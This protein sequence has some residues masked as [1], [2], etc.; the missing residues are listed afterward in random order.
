MGKII[1]IAIG[2][3]LVGSAVLLFSKVKSLTD[4]MKNLIISVGFNGNIKNIKVTITTVTLPL[5]IDFANRSD[6]S[7]TLGLNAMDLIYKN[8]V[9][10]QNSPSATEAVIKPFTTVS[11]PVTVNLSVL[12]LIAVGGD[13]VRNAITNFSSGKIT[14]DKVIS[15]LQSIINNISLYLNVVI[16]RSINYGT[17]VKIGESAALSGFDGLGRP[18]SKK[19]KLKKRMKAVKTV[20]HTAVSMLTPEQKKQKKIMYFDQC[21]TAASCKSRYR[22]LAK[23]LHPDKEGGSETAFQKMQEEYEAK[24]RELQTRAPLNSQEAAELAKAILEI[25]RITKPQYYE[26]IRTVTTVPSVNMLAT[27]FGSLFPEKK[28]TLNGILSILK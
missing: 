19:F 9:I 1:K 14:F 15:E 23:E 3:A 17:T 16:N 6:T 22:E 13:I 24:L 25:L 8:K 7:I 26:I 18:R 27:V 2:A 21:H 28:E 12:N 11:L 20:A 5:K 4:F 10:A